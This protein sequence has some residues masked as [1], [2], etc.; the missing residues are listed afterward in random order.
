MLRNWRI[1]FMQSHLKVKKIYIISTMIIITIALLAVFSPEKTLFLVDKP[2]S[3]MDTKWH[4]S[5][6]KQ[7]YEG[8][9]LPYRF[10][11][12]EKSGFFNATTVLP[13]DLPEGMSILL[14]AS[15]Q[16]V[17]VYLEGQEIFKNERVRHNF[18]VYPEVSM[19]HLITLPEQSAGKE[20]IISYY[21]PVKVFQGVINEVYYG[22]GDALIH[23]V[24]AKHMVGL[25]VAGFMILV[26]LIAIIASFFLKHIGDQR[27]FYLGAF[28]LTSSI[29][30]VS[31]MRVLQW[32][33]GNRFI[34]GGIS[35]LMI[36]LIPIALLR[37][38]EAAVL[39]A[40]KKT[41]NLF[42][43]IFFT[44]FW[45][46][47]GLQL[48]GIVPFIQSAMVV[49]VTIGLA[50]LWIGITMLYEW[51]VKK[52]TLAKH[53]FIYYSVLL[54]TG[55]ME[56]IFFFNQEFDRLTQYDKIGFGLFLVF[57]FIETIRYVKNLLMIQNEAT[58]LEQMAYQ[59]ALTKA[60]NRA[61]Y[62]KELDR[63]LLPENEGEFR[64]I[65]VDINQLKYINDS[66]GHNK[67]DEAIVACYE[68]LIMAFGP[69]GSCYRL[70]GDEFA[71]L[72]TDTNEEHLENAMEH[73]YQLIGK[74]D[75]RFEFPFSVALGEK[76]YQ[77]ES[78]DGRDK[79]R[80]FFHHVD[81]VMYD[82]KKRM[83][84]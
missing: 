55:F 12:R 36:T 73:F 22:S 5:T 7:T 18:P 54:A 9:K 63:L 70:G 66:Y 16:D 19:W 83:K 58:Y 3:E 62:E 75:D 2:I 8:V 41:I 21:S 74:V 17:T 45:A 34:L 77:R 42:V 81:G 30:M 31:E 69:L 49:N 50:I 67:G 26:G 6:I 52:R 37:Y 72:L 11:D 56:I 78:S 4:V 51:L 24:V 44:L 38:L 29:W 25:I 47:L 80:D 64:L 43:T 28:S 35:Y 32:S 39:C 61:A 14:R 27:L 57:Q 71:C 79:F 76:I 46:T 23:H 40:Y 82:T 10:M 13:E 84:A 33:I 68:C 65:L 1:S 20:L 15:M 60:K 59:D 48:V 53:Y